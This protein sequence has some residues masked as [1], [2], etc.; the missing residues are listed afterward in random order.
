MWCRFLHKK[1]LFFMQNVVSSRHEKKSKKFVGMKISLTKSVID[2]A[3]LCQNRNIAIISS[4][5][6][7]N[8][9]Y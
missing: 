1:Q 2:E 6:N 5:K 4:T 8:K 9:D 3:W 7:N